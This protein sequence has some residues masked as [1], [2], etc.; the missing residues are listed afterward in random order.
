MRQHEHT[1]IRAPAGKL[2]HAATLRAPGK[3]ACGRR[4]DGWVLSLRPVNC[5]DCKLALVFD[6]RKRKKGGQ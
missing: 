4:C 5:R 6:A 3:T 1:P 2:V